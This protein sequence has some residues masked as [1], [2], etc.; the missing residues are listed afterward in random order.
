[1]INYGKI[2]STVKPLPLI[3]N[4]Q[5]VTVNS[6][7]REIN[8]EFEGVSHVEYEYTHKVYKTG[9]YINEIT[10][11]NSR[12]EQQVLDTQLAL[13]EVYEVLNA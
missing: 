10:E 6:D 11:E 1:M 12:L 2:R 4:Y 8:V 3:Q 7:I 5:G 13:T 9:E